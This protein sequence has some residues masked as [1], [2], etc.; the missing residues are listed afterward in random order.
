MVAVGIG[1]PLRK[2]LGLQRWRQTTDRVRH[3]WGGLPGDEPSE[4]EIGPHATA[5]PPML[6]PLGR[7]TLPGLQLFIDGYRQ[8]GLWLQKPEIHP[9]HLNRQRG[10]VYCK[11]AGMFMNPQHRC[12]PETSTHIPVLQLHP[13]ALFPKGSPLC[14]VDTVVH[15]ESDPQPGSPIQPS[16]RR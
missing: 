11:E 14:T 8:P 4:Q 15:D 7:H 1:E 10:C 6:P 2:L 9:A 13:T 16:L 5:V 3:F 12:R